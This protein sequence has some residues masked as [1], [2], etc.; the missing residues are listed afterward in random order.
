MSDEVAGRIRRERLMRK[1][2]ERW[3]LLVRRR[4]L[5][6]LALVA[7]LTAALTIP[8]ARLTVPSSHIDAR[9]AVE[10]ALL[11]LALDADGIWTSG[12]VE[13]ASV[14]EALV[15]FRRDHDPQPV[16]ANSEG[17]LR[18]YDDALSRIAAVEVPPV[19]RP[20]Q[21]QFL[22]AITLSRDAVEVLRYAAGQDDPR[23]REALITEA[24][25]L[26]QRSEQLTQSAR[27]SV[28]DLGRGRADVAPLPQITEFS[29]LG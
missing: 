4:H 1:R 25:R 10:I 23:L 2:W 29:G 3:Q 9:R 5:G 18:S 6:L 12:S 13:N 20:V 21:R 8:L 7:L 27:A 19:A 28:D 17:W 22:A 16:L 14:S 24:G 15:A 26:R 11:P